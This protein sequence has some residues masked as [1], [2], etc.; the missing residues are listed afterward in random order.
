MS[1]TVILCIEDNPR[2]QMFNKPLLEAKGFVVRQATTLAQARES[3]AAVM[4]SLIILDIHLPDGNGLDFLRELRKGSTIPV[5]A[6]TNDGAESDLVQGLTSGCDD[7]VTKPH[8]FP[9]LY[10]RIEALLRRAECV[11]EW[12]HKEGFSFD[13]TAGVA[14][15]AG[16]D[17]LL[18]PKEFALL[19]FFV[20]H[21]ECYMSAEELY[22]KV[23]KRA[24][25]N[26]S[27]AL[28]S[29]I[30]RLREK[31]SDSGWCI[32]WSRNEG[33]SFERD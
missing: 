14:S 7:Y 15:F 11:P 5:I 2:V 10:A 30:G 12:V 17:L 6:L 27:S 9:V 26:D 29:A 19:L 18:S 21:A 33:Y 16:R 23:W 20:Q 3:M 4:P 8:T 25:A 32:S 22:Q 13:L 24:L 1:E 28:K 31:I